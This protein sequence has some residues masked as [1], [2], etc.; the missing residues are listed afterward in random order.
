M[1]LKLKN[2]NF[3]KYKSHILLSNVNISEIS[4][5]KKVPFGKQDFEY[6]IGYKDAKKQTFAHITSKNE[7]I[8]IKFNKTRCMYFLENFQKNIMKI[9]KKL[10][11]SSKKNLIVNLY[12]IK[13]V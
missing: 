7:Y 8:Y 3:I 11:I 4:V 5:S 6:F 1:I 9:W 2:T 12:V 13:N 10:A